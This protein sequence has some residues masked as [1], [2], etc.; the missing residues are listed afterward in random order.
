[1]YTVGPFPRQKRG[2][3]KIFYAGYVFFEKKRIAEGKPKS[4]KRHE[5]EEIW[6]GG[7]DRTYFGKIR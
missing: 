1:M 7:V 3:N 2:D 5:M 6:P 4:K